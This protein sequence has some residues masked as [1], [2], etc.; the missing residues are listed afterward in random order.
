MPAEM[1][2]VPNELLIDDLDTLRVLADPV[3]MRILEAMV[4]RLEEW[5]VKELA[6]ALGASAT[7]LY[8]HVNLLEEHGL[9]ATASTRI[10]S[11]IVEK[12]Y[13]VTARSFRIDRRLLSPGTGEPGQE[14]L[15][16]ILSNTFEATRAEIEEGLRTGVLAVEDDAPLERRMTL[17]RSLGRMTPE[18]ALELQERLRQIA[19][20]FDVDEPGDGITYGLLVAMYPTADRPA[21]RAPRR[22]STRRAPAATDPAPEDPR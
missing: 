3:R 8:Y 4:R 5:T 22:K 11:G 20:E 18:R 9:V 7:K 15:H 16:A 13:R 1:Q 10:V 19:A 21:R 2:P 17:S 6:R 14:A 12:R